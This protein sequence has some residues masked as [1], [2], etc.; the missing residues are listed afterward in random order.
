[1]NHG[2]PIDKLTLLKALEMIDTL[3]PSE[4]Y[5]SC[6]EQNDLPNSAWT[7][8]YGFDCGDETGRILT[9]KQLRLIILKALAYD[10]VIQKLEEL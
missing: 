6:D 7:L 10:E 2:D 9:D 8:R 1:M 3:H 5:C 4:P